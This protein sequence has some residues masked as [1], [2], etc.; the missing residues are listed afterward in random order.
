MILLFLFNYNIKFMKNLM[1]KL[2]IIDLDI[3]NFDTKKLND[4]KK[5]TYNYVK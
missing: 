2:F 1:A 5:N 4:K 3:I